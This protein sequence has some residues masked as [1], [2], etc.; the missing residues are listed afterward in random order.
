MLMSDAS[1][2]AQRGSRSSVAAGPVLARLCVLVV[3]LVST[4]PLYA[5]SP[6]AATL[7]LLPRCAAEEASDISIGLPFIAYFA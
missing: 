1:S 5:Q 4:H 3:L 7:D 6:P 2:A